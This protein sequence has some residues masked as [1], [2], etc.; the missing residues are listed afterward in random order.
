[1][2][3]KEVL[4]GIKNMLNVMTL[5]DQVHQLML[6]VYKLKNPEH[7]EID[8]IKYETKLLKERLAEKN[9]TN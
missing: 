1:M 2:N 9:G 7:T 6:E 8:F 4:R 5:R 3:E